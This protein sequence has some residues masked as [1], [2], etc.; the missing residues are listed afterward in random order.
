MTPLQ[1]IAMGLVIIV[2]EA[3][4]GEGW[5]GLPN[6]L[7]WLLVLAGVRAAHGHVPNTGSLGGLAGLALLISAVTYPPGVVDDLDPAAA[8]LLELPQLAFMVVLCFSLA[9]V[10]G[11]S[12]R[13]FKPLG[14][15]LLAVGLGAAAAGQ[16][17]EEG[18][19]AP[20]E[21]V[22]VA[23]GWEIGRIALVTMLF[24]AS[25]RPETGAEPRPVRPTS[26]SAD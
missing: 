25:N 5:D 24:M 11:R 12:G 1:K 19:E 13:W 9:S 17:Q 8:W 4:F 16:A 21:V 26:Q 14:W 7:G 15:V 3:R 10:L 2:I 20:P 18:D 6:P 23:T 22:A